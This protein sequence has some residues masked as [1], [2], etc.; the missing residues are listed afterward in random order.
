MRFES[1]TGHTLPAT[2]PSRQF[3]SNRPELPDRREPGYIG[4]SNEMIWHARCSPL[5]NRLEASNMQV[6]AGASIFGYQPA[7]AGSSTSASKP[8]AI[9][10]GG[11]SQASEDGASGDSGVVQDT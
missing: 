10:N 2:P 7:K 9:D 11:L 6:T 5:R 4:K 1:A 3:F 8:S